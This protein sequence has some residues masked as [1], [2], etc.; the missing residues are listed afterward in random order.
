MSWTGLLRIGEALAAT[1]SD[2]VF[3]RDS[4]PGVHSC[5]LKIHQPK[6]RGRSAKHQVAKI[7]FPDVITL[8]DA[9]YGKRL[10]SEKLWPC[11]LSACGTGLGSYKQHLA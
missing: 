11:Q 5:F 7:D 4:A 3:P 9:V 8:L 6:I 2:L 1:R 10:F